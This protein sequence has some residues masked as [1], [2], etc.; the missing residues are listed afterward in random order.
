[1]KVTNLAAVA[2]TATALSHETNP[3]VRPSS[4]DSRGPCPMLN[5]LANHGYL[6]HNGHDIT[7]PMLGTAIKDSINWSPDFGTVPGAAA[8]AGLNATQIS[9]SELNSPAAAEHK[10]S[11]TRLDAPDDS[12]SVY[13]PRLRAL[14]ADSK[15]DHITIA[16][17]ARSRA[18]VDALSGGTD[19]LSDADEGAA[20]AEAAFVLLLMLDGAIPDASG[21]ETADFAALKAPK[22]RVRV[23]LGEER[24]PVAQGWAPSQRLIPLADLGPVSDAIA[25]AQ[26]G[27]W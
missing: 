21:S 13:T 4:S 16:S 23:W 12:N 14:L 19:I 22:D 18:R 26:G 9:L 7:V 8:F 27:G 1:M 15:T 6:P 3:Y 17:L 25:A 11:L 5:T 10:A 2:A 24:F 20:L